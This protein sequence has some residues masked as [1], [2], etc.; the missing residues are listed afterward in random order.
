MA[1]YKK[2][3]SRRRKSMT[4]PVAP[5]AGLLAV[6][7]ADIDAYKNGGVKGLAVMMQDQ[8]IGKYAAP[9]Y[10][11]IGMGFGAHWLANRLG[12]NRMMGAARIP[13]IRI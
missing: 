7:S 9:T 12:I 5:I 4:I 2:K 3:G 10:T 8:F 6:A 13:L 11:A 1:R